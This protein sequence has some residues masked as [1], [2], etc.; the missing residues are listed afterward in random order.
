M[1]KFIYGKVLST[2]F[3]L[4]SRSLESFELQT[5]EEKL[6]CVCPYFCPLEKGD[7][8]YISE[9]ERLPNSK[10]C[11]LTSEPIVFIGQDE[12]TILDILYRCCN[13]SA[14]G[15]AKKLL[16]TLK[17]E[18][19]ANDTNIFTHLNQIATRW[20][21]NNEGVREGMMSGRF[22]GY[23][24][25]MIDMILNR[26][27]KNRILRQFY[28]FGLN[29]KELENI[30][31]LVLPENKNLSEAFKDFC[32]NPYIFFTLPIKKVMSIANKLGKHKDENFEEYK[33]LSDLYQS[34]NNGKNGY[35][36]NLFQQKFGSNQ[37]NPKN[38]V[39]FQDKIYFKNVHQKEK[40]IA[41]KINKI[42]G[43]APNV[44]DPKYLEAVKN[45]LSQD[46][47][48]ALA[49]VLKKPFGVIYG[50]AGTGKTTILRHLANILECE[51]YKIVLSAFT[52]KAVARIKQALGREDP[53]TLHLLT[54]SGKANFDVLIID[55]ASMVSS[56]LLDQVLSKFS[57][58]FS[59][60]LIGDHYQ[61][62]PI[63]WGRPFYNLIQCDKV[64]SYELTTC[65]RF[66]T[67]EGEENGIIANAIEIREEKDK[68]NIKG[69]TNFMIIQNPVKSV[70]KAC[71]T[72]KI[73]YTD[74]TILCPFNKMLDEIN[75]IASEM[76]LPDNKEIT[77]NQGRP[78]RIGDRVIHLVNNYTINVMNGDE[79]IIQEFIMNENKEYTGL[80][81]HFADEIIDFHFTASKQ[82][83]TPEDYDMEVTEIPTTRHISR[84]YA[85]TIHKSQGSEWNFVC[86]VLPAN[87]TSFINR[88]LFYTA[89]TRARRAIWIISDMKTINKS[90]QTNCEFGS[91]ALPQLL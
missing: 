43:L 28:L 10:T 57:H 16:S 68:A 31:S 70:I 80:K 67:S 20:V 25:A 81:I 87:Q 5:E 48:D 36:Q 58:N 27:Y 11:Q 15:A 24:E 8:V 52:G 35:Q 84:S 75:K 66:L 63:E 77:D 60:Y 53:C 82:E 55:E 17:R 56:N 69:Y 65:H 62:P 64:P 2:K 22:Q 47:Y 29:N 39:T 23:E 54:R 89:I 85:I 91:D 41:N 14:Q 42:L 34:F 76:F 88:N 37:P 78:W 19:E 90:I 32:N 73:P 61:L 46:Q 50:A 38:L 51:G 74:F 12:K 33:K 71:V 83:M 59:L 79:G 9:Y 4:G 86:L 1:S 7:A 26:W 44:Y 3:G 18:S 21:K 13:S 6:H 45:D 72:S 40:N 30:Q 49:N